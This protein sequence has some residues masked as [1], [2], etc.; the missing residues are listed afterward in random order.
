MRATQRGDFRPGID[1]KVATARRRFLNAD[2][3][4][5][6]CFV[7]LAVTCAGSGKPIEDGKQVIASDQQM[8]NNCIG[9]AV[10]LKCKASM[11]R[12]V[13][14]WRSSCAFSILVSLPHLHHHSRGSSSH[15]HHPMTTVLA[16]R[17]YPCVQVRYVTG[18]SYSAIGPSTCQSVAQSQTENSKLAQSGF[19]PSPAR[20]LPSTPRQ[21]SALVLR[22]AS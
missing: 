2:Q 20:Q 5:L 9:F 16:A 19:A 14:S 10:H 3:N 15:H 21:P 4:S 22:A 17:A 12:A 1:F 13:P 18:R 11:L 8:E 7:F 6:E